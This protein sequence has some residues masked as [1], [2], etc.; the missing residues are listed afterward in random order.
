MTYKI[1]HLIDTTGPGGAEEVFIALADHIRSD[2]IDSVVVIRGEGYV[3]QQLRKKGLEPIIID[4][5]G[6]FNFKLIT[7]LCKVVKQHKIKLIQ[8]H[9]LGSNVYA[10]IVGLIMRVPVVATYHG[11][12]DVSPNE[13]FKGLKLW[14]MRTGIAHFVAVSHSLA[15][16]IEQQSLL[17]PN[18]TSVVYNGIDTDKYSSD[19]KDTLR[20]KLGIP[21]TT[22]IFG[23]LGNIRPAKRYDL[24]IEAANLLK[25]QNINCAF[26]IAGDPKAKLRQKLDKQ[27]AYY[28]LD[29]IHFV[30][31]VENTPDYL[32]NLGAFVLTSDAE[33]FSISTIEAMASGLPVLCTKC[34]GPEEIIQNNDQGTL[35]EVNAKSIANGMKN[36]IKQHESGRMV[37]TSAISRVHADFSLKAMTNA[38]KAIYRKVD[39]CFPESNEF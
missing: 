34:G 7:M 23:A 12:V 32:S 6:S 38:Y 25:Q 3:A 10:S 31:F 36:I 28:D 17:I 39:N 14:F 9:L 37:I 4:S 30:G 18:K 8:S 16:K 1:L 5:K 35:V 11:M 2:N 13:R 15:E 24:L 19:R 20:A 26:V 21:P 33:G 29:N 27:I 22:F